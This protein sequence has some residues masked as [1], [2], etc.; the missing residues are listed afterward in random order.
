MKALAYFLMIAGM[1]IELIEFTFYYDELSKKHNK[2]SDMDYLFFATG[3]IS[4]L[5]CLIYLYKHKLTGGL[6]SFLYLGLVQLGYLYISVTIL[7]DIGGNSSSAGLIYTVL[8][9]L[10]GS[11]LLM[12][13]GLM[14]AYWEDRKQPV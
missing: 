6:L 1:L 3:V 13:S 12:N 5:F 14:L 2:L 7:I 9:V 4:F 11:D 8:G 10:F